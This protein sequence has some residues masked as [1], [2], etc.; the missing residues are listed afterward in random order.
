MTLEE[1]KSTVSMEDVLARYGIQPNRSGFIHCPFHNPDKG[2]SMKIHEK[3]WYCFACGETGDQID[4]VA[5]MD[6]LTFKEAFIALGG[7]YEHE[8]KDEVK[9]KIQLAEME[10]RK[11]EE[12]LAEERRIKRANSNLLSAV[13]YGIEHY[14]P[15][16]DVWCMCQNELPLVLN[17]FDRLHG[18]EVGK[19]GR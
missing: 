4:F 2:P 14:P 15:Y 1:I 11:K 18:I 9:R 17:E 19:C 5:Q 7:T 3:W 10:R 13:R 6:N 8:N 16:S 12:K